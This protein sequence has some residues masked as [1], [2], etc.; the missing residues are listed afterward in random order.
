MSV[1]ETQGMQKG[2]W[3]GNLLGNSTW[4]AGKEY[5]E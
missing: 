4:K 3:Y 2:L 5:R 1:T